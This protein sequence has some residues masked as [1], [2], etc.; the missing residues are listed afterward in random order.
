MRST[1]LLVVGGCLAAS[2]VAGCYRPAEK[3]ESKQASGS[4]ES[5]ADPRKPVYRNG[6]LVDD[7]HSKNLQP[8]STVAIIDEARRQAALGA[9]ANPNPTAT[10]TASAVAT[11]NPSATAGPTASPS[12]SAKVATYVDPYIRPAM[13]R[14]TPS[15]PIAMST[16][17]SPVRKGTPPPRTR[18]L[19]APDA[20]NGVLGITFDS[21][22]FDMKPSD[23]FSPKLLTDSVR[24]L[25]DKKVKI[26]GYMWPGTPVDKGV[27]KF[28]FVRDDQ[29][30]CFGPGALIYD[31]IIVSMVPGKSTDFTVRPI[32]VE[33]VLK[34]RENRDLGDQPTSIFHIDADSA[35]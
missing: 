26:R 5:Q 31:N 27:T 21:L 9:A 33:G 4:G 10:P 13:G 12:A 7:R 2:L 8:V 24:A 1:R 28:I 34:Y 19:A 11:S 15:V 29:G 3:A 18:V 16:G 30:C 17:R 32:T 14:P 20:A 35:E 22:M 25:F 23:P 6:E